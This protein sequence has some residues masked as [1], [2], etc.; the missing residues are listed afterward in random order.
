[1]SKSDVTPT[2]TARTS[3]PT[4][5]TV[6]G[7]DEESLREPH[8][9]PQKGQRVV[10]M[11]NAIAPTYERVNALASLGQDARWRRRAVHMARPK[12]GDCIVDV[13]CGTGDM[14]RT[15]ASKRNRKPGRLIGIDFAQEMLDR[16]VYDGVDPQP[17]LTCGD[18][19]A[20]PVS[21]ATADVVSC[22]FGV[23]NFQRLGDGLREM[24]RVLKPG[25]RAIILEFAPPRN[26]LLGFVNRI[27]CNTVLPRLGA[28]VS[29]DSTGA[30]KYLP[31]SIETFET[32]EAM[33]Q[34]LRD[35]GF[36]AVESRGMNLGLVVAYVGTRR[37]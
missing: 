13:C 3:S 6:R 24:A 32:R 7:W 16:G 35:A 8:R 4:T 20:L 14:L 33:E 25:G 12:A 2:A 18:A 21:D 22:A 17:E 1:M 27:Y 29:G 28:W 30:Y 9:D 23:R 34:H 5:D 19:L 10:A 37:A 11:F 36:D 26:A 15:F 31:R